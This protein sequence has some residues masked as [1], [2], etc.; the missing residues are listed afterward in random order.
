MHAPLSALI[1][2]ELVGQGR[3]VASLELPL[4]LGPVDLRLYSKDRIFDRAE[5]MVI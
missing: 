5:G 2:V 3:N 1:V 4:G